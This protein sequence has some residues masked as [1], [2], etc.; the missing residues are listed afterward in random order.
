MQRKILQY[1]YYGKKIKCID[2]NHGP[3]SSK[4][5]V[6]I[7]VNKIPLKFI[8]L[9]DYNLDILEY[10]DRVEKLKNVYSSDYNN[11]SKEDYLRGVVSNFQL[12]V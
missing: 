6:E 5:E 4:I 9:N 10:N 12:Q 1:I 8:G 11:R 3:E 2:H 7:H